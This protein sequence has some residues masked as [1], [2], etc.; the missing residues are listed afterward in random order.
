MSFLRNL[1]GLGPKVDYAELIVNG[2][3]IIDVRSAGEF[4]SGHPQGAINI[5]LENISNS[6]KKIKK[7]NVPIIMVCRSGMR[8]GQSTRTLKSHGIE[9]YNAGAWQNLT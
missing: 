4:K 1:L 9:A 7:Y 5:P 6:I 8:S 3:K 2:A